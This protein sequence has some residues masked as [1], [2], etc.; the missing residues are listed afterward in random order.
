VHLDATDA[1]AKP[2]HQQELKQGKEEG[3]DEEEL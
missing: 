3:D 1:A 2:Y